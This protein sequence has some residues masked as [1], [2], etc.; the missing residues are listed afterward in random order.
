MSTA[1]ETCTG[2]SLPEQYSGSN[3]HFYKTFIYGVHNTQK[4][5]SYLATVIYCGTG[6]LSENTLYLHYKD[7]PVT[8]TQG[9]NRCLLWVSY[10]THEQGVLISP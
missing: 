6:I 10:T 1:L 7:Q 2:R 8:F 4:L 5:Y 3:F 9:K